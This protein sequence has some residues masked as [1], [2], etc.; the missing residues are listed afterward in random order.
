M[1]PH[2]GFH[3]SEV[4]VGQNF[5]A[6][7]RTGFSNLTFLGQF[8]RVLS[9]E[10]LIGAAIGFGEGDILGS[11]VVDLR[12][13]GMN[14]ATATICGGANGT[15]PSNQ[16]TDIV[17]DLASKAGLVFLM[18]EGSLSPV[19]ISRRWEL[20]PPISGRDI[21]SVFKAVCERRLAGCQ[22]HSSRSYMYLYL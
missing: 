8:G 9:V 16:G 18:S 11:I 22:H 10:N 21:I 5:V 7:S 20:T 1:D 17:P 6:A 13:L 14:I 2:C 12:M 19:E 15:M 4:P 3:K